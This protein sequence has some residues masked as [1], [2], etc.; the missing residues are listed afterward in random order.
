MS[1]GVQG[2]PV[3][4]CSIVYFGHA[5]FVTLKEGGIILLT[6]EIS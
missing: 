3:A 5:G 6:A 2:N 1:K 4:I